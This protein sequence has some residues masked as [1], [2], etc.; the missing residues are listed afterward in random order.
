MNYNCDWCH[1]EFKKFVRYLKGHVDPHNPRSKGKKGSISDQVVCPNCQRTIPTW[2]RINI[3]GHMV[4]VG[5][6]LG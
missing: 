5:R 4:R 2:R 6:N 3:D 1:H